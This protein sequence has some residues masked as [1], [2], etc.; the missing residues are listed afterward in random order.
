MDELVVLENKWNDQI[1]NF[2]VQAAK[3]EQE[4]F[5][6]I[7]GRDKNIELEKK[8]ESEIPLIEEELEK[9]R[10]QIAKVEQSPSFNQKWNDYNKR[11]DQVIKQKENEK[12]KEW[13]QLSE[14][15]QKAIDQ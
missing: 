4:Y 14:S 7:S 12:Q 5:Q 10:D 9:I 3:R 8:L 13:T 15:F 6:I 2:K 11:K 1:E